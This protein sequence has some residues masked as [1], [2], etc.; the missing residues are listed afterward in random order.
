MLK[1]KSGDKLPEERITLRVAGPSCFVRLIDKSMPL[2]NGINL[3]PV[4]IREP[5]RAK[6]LYLYSLST[7]SPYIDIYIM[8]IRW[9]SDLRQWLTP[10]ND[11]SMMNTIRS[12]LTEGLLEKEGYIAIPISAD[13]LL[14]YS[15]SG[16]GLTAQI[17]SVENLKKIDKLFIN[18]DYLGESLVSIFPSFGCNLPYKTL[19]CPESINALSFLAEGN[20][21]KIASTP[22]AGLKI[23]ETTFAPASLLLNHKEFLIDTN[24]PKGSIIPSLPYY[25]C[26]NSASSYKKE[27][28]VAIR[29]ILSA[30][31]QK[32]GEEMGL[33]ISPLIESI[34]QK[35]RAAE[36]NALFKKIEFMNIIISGEEKR[37]ISLGIKDVFSKAST[38]EEALKRMEAIRLAGNNQN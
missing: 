27:S 20:K 22:I 13:C 26:I 14:L 5:S 24:I 4:E 30:E 9:L 18:E 17:P 15:R 33:W 1:C 36:I 19:Y 8:D 28:L 23:G 10:I 29:A 11:K 32:R 16:K 21:R 35:E 34:T 31:F 2:L 6:S 37:T 3:E 38:P 12:D 25:L 7:H